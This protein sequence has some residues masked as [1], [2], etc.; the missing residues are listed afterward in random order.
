MAKIPN[1]NAEESA[2]EERKRVADL[3]KRNAM[4]AEQR[5]QNLANQQSYTDSLEQQKKELEIKKTRQQGTGALPQKVG[6]KIPGFDLVKSR[7]QEELRVLREDQAKEERKFSS[8]I[9]RERTQREKAE[10]IKREIQDERIRRNLAAQRGA[11]AESPEGVQ[12]GALG[13]L[14][15]IRQERGKLAEIGS[16]QKGIINS[17]ILK[18][19]AARKEAFKQQN[20][21]RALL[22]ETELEKA[23]T[24]RALTEESISEKGL[25]RQRQETQDFLNIIR[26]FG[27]GGLDDTTIAQGV[28]FGISKGL[29]EKARDDALEAQILAKKARETQSEQDI[30][31]AQQARANLEKTQADIERQSQTE[32][33]KLAQQSQQID[34]YVR[35]KII[36]EDQAKQMRIKIGLEESDKPLTRLD[37]AKAKKIELENLVAQQEIDITNNDGL[38]TFQNI[39]NGNITQN[40]GA[41][42][43]LSSDNVKLQNG[44]KGTPGVD[45]DGE[46]GDVIPSFVAGTVEFAGDTKGG[47]G[48]SVQIRDNQGN[49]HFYNHLKDIHVDKGQKI[50]KGE[51]VA[52]MGNSGNVLDINGNIP[53][54]EQ[55]AQ[56]IGS[57]LDYRIKS[58]S[59]INGSFWADPNKF[60]GIDNSQL[61]A[62]IQGFVQSRSGVKD[63]D[64]RLQL[65]RNI[66]REI[67]SGRATTPSEAKIN[68]GI[69]SDEDK[70]VKKRISTDLAP[71]KKDTN[72]ILRS[73]KNIQ[74][75]SIIEGGIGDVATITAFLKAIDPGSV[76]RESEVAGVESARGLIESI[77]TQ[78]SKLKTGQK[79]GD[80]QRKQLQDAAKVLGDS[81]RANLYEKLI[82]NRQELLDR[83]VEPTIIS[84]FQINKLEREM[85]NE[86]VRQIK[87]ENNLLEDTNKS[88][89]DEINKYGAGELSGI[90]NEFNL[91]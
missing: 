37:I 30:L 11:L 73:A 83:G 85:G 27:A 29:L 91:K 43:S 88:I 7:Q 34:E 60:Q 21:D 16:I 49:L 14:E 31:K 75:L 78:I 76:A 17:K 52:E 65:E 3:K 9:D 74:N 55:R 42:S 35:D 51:V 61:K 47:L 19:E 72:E 2:R 39:G 58:N 40:Y 25:Q 89:E 84:D 63:K 80:I 64:A 24:Q 10:A 46:L 38:I 48:L 41:S 1:F 77:D 33:D 81:A 8:E 45:I 50:G 54:E 56:G 4:L 13:V 18:L 5:Q 86:K 70:E 67:Q 32:V 57:H 15:P 20:F 23:K 44:A 53:T 90:Q 62:K 87:I 68:L 82:T 66:L 6:E 36:T 12:T 26:T 28:S 59:L 71:I 69:V 79:L 22:I